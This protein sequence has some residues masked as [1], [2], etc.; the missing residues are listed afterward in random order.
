MVVFSDRMYSFQLGIQDPSTPVAEGIIRFHGDLLSLMVGVV[1]FVLVLLGRIIWQFG[2][3][4]WFSSLNRVSSKVVH[5][6]VLE[7]IWTILPALFLVGLSVPSFSLLYAVDEITDPKI[8]L[9]VVGHQWYWSYEINDTGFL[10]EF[11]SYLVNSTELHIGELR[12][13]EVDSRIVLPERVHVRLVVT[14]SDVIHSFAILSFG[15][16]IDC[17]PGRLNEC[18]FFVKRVGVYYGQC[19]ELCGVNHAFMPICC[20]IV[21]FD[22]YYGWSCYSVYASLV[23]ARR[24]GGFLRGFSCY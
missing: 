14:S 11:D 20:E 15:L 10:V 22:S 13:L 23:G 16:K 18:S 21:D 5:G 1:V 12:L 4:V 3:S 8:T 7:I 24:Y 19:S 9:K 17:C 2:C 6:V